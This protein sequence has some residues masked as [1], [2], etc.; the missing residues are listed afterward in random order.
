MKRRDFISDTGRALVAAAVPGLAHAQAWPSRPIRAITQDGPGGA[1][2][3]RL[4]EF[5]P[6]LA[7]EL[8]TTVVV[9]N[10]PG[11]AGQLAHQAVLTQPADGYTIL[12]ANATMTIVPAL[13]RN[14]RYSTIR[15]FTPVAY[16]GLSPIGLGI[17]ASRPEKTLAEWIAWAK[18]QKGRLNY[19]SGG[20]GTVQ[21]LYGFQ[22]NED[23]DLGATHV[24]YKSAIQFLPD[25]ATNQLQFTM[26]DIFSQRPFRERG[27][28][29]ILAVTGD[30]RSKFLPDVPT[31]KELGHP[32]YDRMGWTAYYVKAGTP[33][34]IVERLAGAINRI[35]A[36]P[37]WA[38]RREATWSQWMPLSPAQLAERVRH[39]ADAWAALVKKTGVYAD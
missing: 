8:K 39:E 30:E 28:V 19:G 25:L 7:E 14:L 18:T 26:L 21:H 16:S 9:E 15:D 17:P 34:A 38:A 35:S 32:G 36:L 27:T 24:P 20:N 11:A 2:D 5:V 1:V 22:V 10:K 4:R 37:E 33:P 13:Y 6:A 31:F 3:A 12:L 29:R 23:F